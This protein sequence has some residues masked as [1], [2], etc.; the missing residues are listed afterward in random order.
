MK[1][2][3]ADGTAVYGHASRKS[4]TRTSEEDRQECIHISVH[5]SKS[6]AVKNSHRLVEE[7]QEVREGR[8]R[9]TRGKSREKVPP[10][11]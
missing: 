5:H 9:E 1:R 8:E 3:Q 10:F 2:E 11:L 4:I 6:E 7:R